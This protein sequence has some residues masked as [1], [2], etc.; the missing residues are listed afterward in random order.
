MVHEEILLVVVLAFHWS[1]DCRHLFHEENLLVGEL[2][3][4]T[5]S[6]AFQWSVRECRHS[7]QGAFVSCDDQ[8]RSVLLTCG[9]HFVR[10]PV[11]CT[12][13]T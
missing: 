6:L 13:H 2:A 5:L 3:I 8:T 9:S 12:N 1:V 7:W 10:L 4:G 11:R